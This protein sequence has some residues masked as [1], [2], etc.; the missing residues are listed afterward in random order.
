MAVCV[1]LAAAEEE[2]TG[3]IGAATP[4]V[5][6]P[7]PSFCKVTASSLPLGFNP[8][9]AW[10]FLM[11]SP[12]ELS[13]F[14]LGVPVNDPSF[15]R[16]CCISEMR[17]GVGAFCPR[18]R[19]LECLLD[20]LARAPP[21]E[22]EP[23]ALL[24]ALLGFAGPEAADTPHS[25]ASS[26]ARVAGMAF[27]SRISLDQLYRRPAKARNRTTVDCPLVPRRTSTA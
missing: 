22:A 12:V 14:P 5:C 3:G 4:A 23:D 7:R 17:S 9:P 6:E 16:A 24:P 10:N 13:H 15:A 20:F 11:A 8:C 25:A 27:R 2:A 19:R 26:S 18:S 21:L 1:V